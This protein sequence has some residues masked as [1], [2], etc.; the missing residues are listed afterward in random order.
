MVKTVSPSVSQNAPEARHRAKQELTLTQFIQI[1]AALQAQARRRRDSIPV[2][3]RV[4]TTA[5]GGL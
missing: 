2:I 3:S 1:A 5:A 4:K